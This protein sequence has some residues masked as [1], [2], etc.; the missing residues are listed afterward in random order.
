MR[1]PINQSINQS[2]LIEVGRARLLLVPTLSR[3]QH[4]R[5]RASRISK[6]PTNL[7]LHLSLPD[8]ELATGPR[9]IVLPLP[10][11][12]MEDHH[13]STDQQSVQRAPAS[14]P[15]SQQQASKQASRSNPSV[16]LTTARNGSR[17]DVRLAT[18][19]CG[20]RG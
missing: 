6:L 8:S 1:N 2:T 7:T 16:V 19:R 3:S 13:R 9:K 17:R 5:R 20:L 14:Q 18:A 10:P 15:A 12:T 4:P 11:L